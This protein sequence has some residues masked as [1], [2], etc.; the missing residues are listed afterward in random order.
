MECQSDL[1]TSPSMVEEIDELLSSTMLEMP[2]QPPACTFP[3]RP[4]PMAP[5]KPVANKGEVPSDP[6]E[7]IPVYLKELLPSPTRVLTSWHG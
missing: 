3:R 6:G 5:N 4:P 2:G 7:A 1:A